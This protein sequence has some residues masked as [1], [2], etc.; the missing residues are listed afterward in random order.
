LRNWEEAAAM[1]FNHMIR[2]S[3]R[4][5]KENFLYF[6]SLIIAI[7][8]GY[9]LLSLGEQ[10]VMIFLKTL[11]SDAVRKLLNLIPILYLISLFFVFFLVYFSNRYQL[12]RRNHEFGIYQILGMRRGRLFSLLM[13]ETIWNSLIAL[14]IGIPIALF[15][16]ELISLATA[17][18]VGM[19]IIGH[20]FRVSLPGLLG[21]VAGFMA[22]QVLAMILLSVRMSRK[23]PIEL[24]QG[25]KEAIQKVASVKS[26]RG[27]LL[28][29]VILL[30]IA[31]GFGIFLF[32]SLSLLVLLVIL[33]AGITGT[34]LVFS[35]LATFIGQWI[36]KRN[37]RSTGLLSFT[38]RQLQENVL[39][40]SKF[41]AIASL[42]VLMAIMCLSYGVS[43]VLGNVSYAD[44][45]VD[46]S[47]RGEQQ[48]IEEV[49]NSE[50]VSPY[51]HVYY[52]MDLSNFG[53]WTFGDEGQLIEE[54]S[55]FSWD[56]LIT[57]IKA[58][59]NV[60]ARIGLLGN[61]SNRSPFL[62]SLTSFNTLLESMGRQ[63]ITL[64]PGELVMYASKALAIHNDELQSVL[65]DHPT[66]SLG[67]EVYT[68]A[69]DLQ[70]CNLVA[71]S[72]I[73]VMYALIVPDDVYRDMV[74]DE[75]PYCWNVALEP[76]YIEEQG[77]MQALLHVN[78]LLADTNLERESYLSG[79]GRQLFYIV[80]GSYLT[81][82]L[83]IL[84]LIIANTVLG[85]KFLMQQRSTR[86][87]YETLLILGANEEALYSSIKTQIRIYFT[88]VIGVAV[89]SSIFGIGSMFRSIL[90]AINA[91]DMG[92]L[93]IISGIA[94]FVF[95]LIEFCYIW[96]IQSESGREIRRLNQ[97]NKG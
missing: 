56:G 97:M 30:L 76:N 52:P 18:L 28:V 51:I 48:E 19:G 69:S 71:D 16:T 61:I 59:P 9:V 90:M 15:L 35:G 31:Y 84:F 25:E 91:R 85:I 54:S 46:F 44:R 75:P 26:G 41:L 3:R 64:K 57:G 70:T 5:R 12:Q 72:F 50:E 22:V 80:A 11:E 87:R 89:I 24:L 8:V 10:D 32:H 13:G 21:T 88:L 37:R 86:H 47:F 65:Q 66:V 29:G 27:R 60:N 68:L 17:K 1:F 38:G 81:L 45:A 53:A 34:F 82:Y 43:S 36:Q 83:G 92:E 40:Q 33:P 39:Y 77:L 7:V 93:T 2:N 78:E 73:S 23:D 49:L 63:K 62:I 20:Q 55:N 67:G 6:G 4:S 58:L 14:L 96:L 79:I 42:L 95:L 94:V 74:G